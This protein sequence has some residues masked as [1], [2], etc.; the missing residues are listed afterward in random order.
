MVLIPASTRGEVLPLGN[1]L[2]CWL[3]KAMCIGGNYDLGGARRF[4]V[5][6]GVDTGAQRW[7][8][9][10]W[11]ECFFNT[12]ADQ[13]GQHIRQGVKKRAQEGGE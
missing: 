7:S 4:I 13:D 8:G 9:R 1:F 11:G 6:H 3:T 5:Q 12:M 10:G 2:L